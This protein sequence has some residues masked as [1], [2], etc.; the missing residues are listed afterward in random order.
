M[1]VLV[2]IILTDIV[3]LRQRPKYNGFVSLSWAVGS[4]TGPLIGGAIAENTTWRWI[5]YLNFPLCAAALVMIPLVLKLEID[6]TSLK[7]KLALV[8]WFGNV[9]FIASLTS[10]LVAV[11]WGGV[12][13]EVRTILIWK[14]GGRKVINCRSSN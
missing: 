6:T 12:Q 4:M 13:F 14:C 8:D 9:L 2:Y 10:F 7:A 5:F 3:P 11:T 1:T